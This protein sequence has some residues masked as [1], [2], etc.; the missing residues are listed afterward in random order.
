[1]A[2]VA[3]RQ[4]D[5]H[6]SIPTC[7][8][9]LA[10]ASEVGHRRNEGAAPAGLDGGR[11]DSDWNEVDKPDIVND[12]AAKATYAGRVRLLRQLLLL[13]DGRCS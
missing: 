6:P 3:Q 13:S 12:N 4:H 8:S 9:S 2:V 7:A 11:I 1:M 10:P 5:V